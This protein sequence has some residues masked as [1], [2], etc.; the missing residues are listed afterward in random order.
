VVEATV[1]QRS[2]R[3]VWHPPMNVPKLAQR[4]QSCCNRLPQWRTSARP[5]ALIVDVF[6]QHILQATQD[7]FKVDL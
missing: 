4:S 3:V 2:E 5:Q 7:N 1:S 6:S